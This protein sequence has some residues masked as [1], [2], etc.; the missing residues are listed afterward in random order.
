MTSP[1]RRTH[2]ERSCASENGLLS[3]MTATSLTNP[4]IRPVEQNDRN[5]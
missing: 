4:R 2:L 1:S 3:Q 5:L